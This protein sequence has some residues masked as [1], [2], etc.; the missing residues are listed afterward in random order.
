MDGAK[1]NHCVEYCWICLGGRQN[2]LA[3]KVGWKISRYLWHGSMNIPESA[4]RISNPS[5]SISAWDNNTTY[6][7]QKNWK[8]L[9][10]WSS[11]PILRSLIF[12]MLVFRW[13]GWSSSGWLLGR[14]IATYP[15]HCLPV[16]VH[17]RQWG[18]SSPHLTLRNLHWVVSGT[19][20]YIALWRTLT[21]M[22]HSRS[23]PLVSLLSV[24]QC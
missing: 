8:P 22:L 21:C 1:S 14:M 23:L 24:L 15:S 16:D 9:R 3:P 13:V 18:F 19:G 2:Q 7:S 5:G 12:S 10:S 6:F 11:A 4:Q 20:S 17:R